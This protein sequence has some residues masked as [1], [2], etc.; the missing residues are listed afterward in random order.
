MQG[1]R[2]QQ[3]PGRLCHSASAGTGCSPVTDGST[4]EGHVG[5]GGLCKGGNHE[6]CFQAAHAI[7]PPA[8][9]AGPPMQGLQCRASV[10]LSP[11]HTCPP[12]P[13]CT[14]AGPLHPAGP[15]CTPSGLACPV[16]RAC[17]AMIMRAH[18]ISLC[19]ITCEGR[20]QWVCRGLQGF[21]LAHSEA[22]C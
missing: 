13:P 9:A 21:K 8:T 22:Y 15:P 4:A 12:L 2:P 18:S 19:R 6:G 17:V 1:Q 3:G 10:A 11:L 16:T 20:A 5:R 14:P 7:M